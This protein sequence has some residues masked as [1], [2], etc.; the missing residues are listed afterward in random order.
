G[1]PS[2]DYEVEIETGI[3]VCE[4]CGR[5]F[6]ITGC[7]PE[8]LP[9]HL[10]N[11]EKEARFFEDCAERLPSDLMEVLRAAAVRA[12]AADE[13]GGS[14]Y[15]RA[16]IGI[17]E[18][19]DNVHFFSPGYSSPFNPQTT[20]FT[21]YLIK[22]FGAAAPLLELKTGDVLLDSGCGYA[23]TTEWFYKA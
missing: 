6:P 3:L 17:S 5:W 23:W 13:D 15:K 14:S 7:L 4:P 22:L 1:P 20:E 18:K 10:R 8:L 16:E 19:V 12:E 11:H 9:D 2:R 21:L